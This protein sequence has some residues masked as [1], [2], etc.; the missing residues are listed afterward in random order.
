MQ[1][2]YIKL[3]YQSSLRVFTTRRY[4]N[5]RSPLP[6]PLPLPIIIIIIIIIIGIRWH[7]LDGAQSSPSI[8]AIL[9]GRVY[10]STLNWGQD[11]VVEGHVQSYEVI[12]SSWS[13]SGASPVC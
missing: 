8:G 11:G 10:A 9:N 3:L 6:L 12:D 7:A 5:P 4:T 2:N 13:L 1:F